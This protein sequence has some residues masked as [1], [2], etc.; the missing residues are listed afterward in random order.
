M[1]EAEVAADLGCKEPNL[2]TY[3]TFVGCQD[4]AWMTLQVEIFEFK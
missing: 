1:V 2:V 3:L 4:F